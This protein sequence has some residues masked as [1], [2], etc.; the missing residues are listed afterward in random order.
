MEPTGAVE[1]ALLLAEQIGQRD[2]H[3]RRDRRPGS[4]GRTP[5]LHVVQRGLPADAARGG[6]EEVA[7]EPLVLER[8]GERDRDDVVAL[9]LAPEVVAIGD[10]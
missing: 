7:V 10:A 9:L 1:D 2:Q 4:D 5:H 8:P 6:R 3:R